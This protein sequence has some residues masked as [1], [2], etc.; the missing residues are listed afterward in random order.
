MGDWSLAFKQSVLAPSHLKAA[1]GGF[2]F[3]KADHSRLQLLKQGPNSF[4]S[5]SISANPRLIETQGS[6]AGP[7]ITAES[8]F[9]LS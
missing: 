1:S 9:M 3:S 6:A 2:R 4:P 5:E 7:S 8:G